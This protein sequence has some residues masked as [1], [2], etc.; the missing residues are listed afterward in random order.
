M[1]ADQQL[2]DLYLSGEMTLDEFIAETGGMNIGYGM[3]T[4]CV[5]RMRLPERIAGKP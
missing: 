3:T 2:I 1:N 5:A 4:R